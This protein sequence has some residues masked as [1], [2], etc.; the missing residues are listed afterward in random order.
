VLV[1]AGHRCA[2]PTCRHPTTEIAHIVPRKPD[3]SNDVFENLIALCPNDHARYDRGE[4][5]RQSM[6]MYKRN[7]GLMTSRYSDA[8]RRLLDL[9]ARNPGISSFKADRAMDFEFMY[10][11]EDGLL[12]K[13][14]PRQGDAF[15]IIMGVRQ[16]PAQYILT[17][18]GRQLVDRLSQGLAVEEGLPE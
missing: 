3:G 17:P 1:E 7:L 14:P 8:E 13:A 2:I 15:M 9:F 4:I 6:V 5:D 12:V 16:G 11:I 10:L 18:A